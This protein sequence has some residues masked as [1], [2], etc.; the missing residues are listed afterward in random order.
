MRYQG[1]TAAPFELGETPDVPAA[2][3]LFP[4]LARGVRHA[5][6]QLVGCTPAV[7]IIRVPEQSFVRD[8]TVL[9]ATNRSFGSLLHA[10]SAD[11]AA[12]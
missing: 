5:W 3:V 4:A 2:R 6:T 10:L 11:P 7:I 12:P 9:S 8:T 1:D